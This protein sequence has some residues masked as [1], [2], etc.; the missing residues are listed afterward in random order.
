MIV[1]LVYVASFGPFLKFKFSFIVLI[2]LGFML[3]LEFQVFLGVRK[4][5]V[6]ISFKQLFFEFFFILF[7]MFVVLVFIGKV[8]S[9]FPLRKFY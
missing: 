4:I 6:I 8:F 2:L 1:V 5:I 7:L 9:Y 3:F